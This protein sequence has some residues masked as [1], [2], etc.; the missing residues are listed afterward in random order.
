MIWIGAI[1]SFK[2]FFH[3]LPDLANKRLRSGTLEAAGL[4]IGRFLLCV[5]HVS[6]PTH[7]HS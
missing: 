5:E 7:S 1:G 2:L 6:Y 3:W 4:P